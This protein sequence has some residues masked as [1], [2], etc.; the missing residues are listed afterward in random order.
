[1][2][3]LK[4]AVLVDGGSAQLGNMLI[5]G[6]I[7]LESGPG[8]P[9]PEEAQVLDLKGS[10]VIPGLIDAHTH[11]GG[12][13]SFERPPHTGRF[14]SYD[15]AQHREAALEWGV[16]AVRSAGDFMPDIVEIRNLASSGQIRSPRIQTAGRM[17]QAPGG[18][19]WNTVFFQ[20]PETAAHELIFAGPDTDLELEVAKLADE[21]VDWIKLYIS[22]DDVTRWPQK[23]PRLSDDQLRQ[24]TCA[25]HSL[26]KA[27]MAHVDNFDG[28]R[29]AVEV[30][31]DSIEHVLNNG[32]NHGLTPDETLLRQLVDKNIWVVPTMTATKYH[33][34]SIP[35]AQP[36]M[37][38]LMDGVGKLIQ[39]GVRL[40]VGCDSGIP[41]VP[42]G[43]CVH[44]ELE[45]LC[46]AGMTPEQALSAA[47]RGN[48]ELL[49]WEGQAGILA[50]GGWADLVVLGSDPRTDISHTQDIQMVLQ[51]GHVV[52]DRLL[53]L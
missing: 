33:D 16:T 11:L 27:V 35:Q 23:L 1:M 15:Y 21:G 5:Q 47:T 18:H 42:Y 30:G 41:L 38:W 39:A 13:A 31:A 37:P 45:L 25:A 10:Y 19:P 12:S 14:V 29:L 2:L 24:A 51:G 17:I 3:V 53:N 28:M 46:Q 20:N 50:P 44:E 22:E 34:G 40:G 9:I 52:I 48:A 26:G 4:D 6:E 8:C 43:Q 36:I 32:A 49:G 7:I